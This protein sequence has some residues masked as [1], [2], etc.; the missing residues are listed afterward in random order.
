MAKKNKNPKMYPT[1]PKEQLPFAY[2]IN[3]YTIPC[4]VGG[5]GRFN[6]YTPSGFLYSSTARTLEDA[7]A[8][9]KDAVTVNCNTPCSGYLLQKLKIEIK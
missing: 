1:P 3:G 7:I 2:V 8:I 6:I 9:A 4:Y 5:V